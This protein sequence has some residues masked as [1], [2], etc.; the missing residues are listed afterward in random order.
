MGLIQFP[1]KLRPKFVL[2]SK[3]A[4]LGI[5]MCSPRVEFANAKLHKILKHPRLRIQV[6]LKWGKRFPYLGINL[7]LSEV[8]FYLQEL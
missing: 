1:S 4:G 5:L 8:I 2:V 6:G 3:G 7:S